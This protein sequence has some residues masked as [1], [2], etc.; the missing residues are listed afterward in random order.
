M[1]AGDDVVHQSDL[2]EMMRVMTVNAAHL[3]AV[4]NTA[5]EIKEQLVMMNGHVRQNQIDL[6]AIKA[7]PPL[8]REHC[9]KQREE[10]EEK[11]SVLEERVRRLEERLPSIIQNIIVALLTG[12]ALGLVSYFLSRIP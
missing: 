11:R 1:A 7:N 10:T 5:G 6:A 4:M 12:G 3:E 9:D 2:T 8:T